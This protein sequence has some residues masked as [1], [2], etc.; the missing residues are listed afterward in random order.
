MREELRAAEDDE[1]EAI[2]RLDHAVWLETQAP[3]QPS[4]V[5]EHRDEAFFIERVKRLPVPPLAVYGQGRL[6][7]FA[8]WADNLLGQLYVAREGRRLGIGRALLQASEH[9]IWAS[10]FDRARLRCLVGNHGARSFYERCGWCC[11][12]TITEDAE[13]RAGPVPVPCWEM[14]KELT[15]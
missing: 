11:T 12:A 2:G 8:A 13:T 14:V 6:L 10:G 3:L 9:A 4:S 5:A 15:V 7:G 1:L